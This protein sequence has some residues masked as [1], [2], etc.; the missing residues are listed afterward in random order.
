[1][2]PSPQTQMVAE[3]AVSETLV[4][5]A[6]ELAAELII[7][8]G[9]NMAALRARLSNGLPGEQLGPQ[10]PRAIPAAGKGYDAAT[11]LDLANDKTAQAIQFI[12]EQAAAAVVK[13]G[14]GIRRE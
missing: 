13:Q 4:R 2:E 1:M 8:D 14:I 7:R 6:I 10:I 9:G 5:M 3:M 12:A 11:A